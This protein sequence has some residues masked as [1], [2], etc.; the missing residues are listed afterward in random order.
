MALQIDTDGSPPPHHR[1]A[2]VGAGF[3]GLGHGDPAQAGG[4]RGLRRAR[5]RAT[6]SAAPGATTPTRA[7]RATCPSHLYSFSF[8]P[9]PDWTR[10]FSPQPEIRDYLRDCADELGV[11]RAHPLRPRGHER[12]L[13]RATRERW[14]IE[15]SAGDADRRVLVAGAGPLSRAA[16][17]RA[18]PGIESF[19]GDVFHSARWDHE[20][21]PRRRARRGDRHRRVGDPV[22][23]ADPA[24]RSASC[25]CSSARRRGSCRS[26]DRPITTRR[27]AAVPRACRRR[28]ARCAPAIYCGAR[29]AAC[30][31]V[32]A[33][34][35]L[36]SPRSASRAGT[37][38]AQVARPGAARA[39]SRRDYRLGCK[40]ILSPTTT[41]RRS[42]QP[43]V[44]VVT[45]ADRASHAARRSSPPTA[46]EREV[47]T[48][49][50]GT[51]F[52]VTDTPIAATRSAAATGA[53]WPTPGSGS[54]QAYL[55]TTVAGFPNLFLLVGPEHRARPQLDRV[56]DRGAA[57]LPDRRARAHARARRS[58]RR[59]ARARSQRRYDDGGPAAHAG[60]RLERR[61]LRELVPRRARQEHDALAGLDLALPAAA[62]ALRARRLPPAPAARTG[63]HTRARARTRVLS[64][65]D[66]TR[67]YHPRRGGQSP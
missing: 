52:H 14:R 32:H 61:R 23:P 31:A 57:A 16:A 9:N 56:H 40:R 54:P 62:A 11:R 1:I 45:D 7:A 44:E 18:S 65:V 25:T 36:G 67:L 58:S 42:T 64:D 55:G 49:I 30:S 46:R 12:A 60:H 10:T 24:A 28:S 63:D 20:L 2:I 51:G 37:C 27:A 3:A 38:A 53:R 47:D 66:R 8:A 4:H 26:R 48:I 15:T 39:G 6:T 17:P 35:A 13:G 43:N 21:R 41:T 59:G 19:E 22:R 33:T 34:R 50:F 5:A 29:A